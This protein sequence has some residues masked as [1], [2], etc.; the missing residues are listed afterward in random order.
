MM[1]RLL[2]D[3]IFYLAIPLVIWNLGRDKIGT[4]YAM[5]LS[6]APGFVYIMYGL[7]KE[8]NYS[9]T[10]IFILI[11]IIVGRIGD[12]LARS[13]DGV[14]WN[15]V[16][17]S[18]VFVAFYVITIL[19][20]RPMGLYIF[21]DYAYSQGFSREESE[22]FLKRK[23]WFKYLQLLTILF[24]ISG[25]EGVLLKIWLINKFGVDGF[26]ALSIILSINGY[27][28]WGVQVLFLHRE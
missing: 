23:E 27:V 4:Y 22:S 15:G 17:I 12:L 8:R 3:I 26:N 21:V 10:G 14:L 25:L 9:V 1:K 6:G 2:S 19:I 20:K 13:P 5:I 7:I 11:S 18:F 28:L 24:A 16:Y